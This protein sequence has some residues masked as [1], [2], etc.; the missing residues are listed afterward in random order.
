MDTGNCQTGS[1]LICASEVLLERKSQIAVSR[2]PRIIL[3]SATAALKNNNNNK[4]LSRRALKR[5]VKIVRYYN[6]AYLFV[7][8]P[9]PYL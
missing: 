3:I 5:L 4:K 8:A 2:K 7:T 1:H 6:K 9:L